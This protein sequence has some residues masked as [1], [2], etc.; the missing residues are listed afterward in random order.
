MSEREWLRQNRVGMGRILTI[1]CK[2][3]EKKWLREEL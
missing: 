1:L 2:W 3:R